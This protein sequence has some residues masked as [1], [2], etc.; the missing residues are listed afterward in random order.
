[1]K[2]TFPPSLF[3]SLLP[4]LPA[5]PTSKAAFNNLGVALQETGNLTPAFQAY[6][7]ALDVDGLYGPALQNLA[8]LTV[9]QVRR[10]SLFPLPSSLPPSLPPSWLRSHPASLKSL[11][12][13][14]G[15]VGIRLP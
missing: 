14:S 5:D 9:S 10:P 1:M 8:A 6:K 15:N 12:L 11:S 4:S 2:P 13:P 3:P 7:K